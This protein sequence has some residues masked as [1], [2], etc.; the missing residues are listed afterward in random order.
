MPKPGKRPLPK[1]TKEFEET[2][3]EVARVTRVV[4]GGRRMRFRATVVIGNKKGTVG[5]GIGKAVEVQLAI[6]KAVAKAKKRLLRVPLYKGSIPHQIQVK[7]KSSVVFVKPASEGTGL[8]AGGA[9]RQILELAGVRNVLSKSLGSNNRVNTAK[10]AYKALT[11]LRERPDMETDKVR[12]EAREDTERADP[13]MK[14]MSRKE[15]HEMVNADKRMNKPDKKH[16]DKKAAPK[17]D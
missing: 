16:A 3:V 9:L 8:I 4:K 11:K 7:F 12:E 13:E 1:E 17:K 6:Q 10:A 15:A 2:V 5:Y 14:K